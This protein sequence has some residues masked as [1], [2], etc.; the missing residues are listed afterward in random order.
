MGFGLGRGKEKTDFFCS[1]Y[2]VLRIGH[3]ERE[4]EREKEV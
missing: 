2:V 1:Y 4:R 3:D